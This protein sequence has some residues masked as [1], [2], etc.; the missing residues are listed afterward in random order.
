METKIT[1]AALS[2]RQVFERIKEHITTK[3]YSPEFQEVFGSIDA[4]Y[5]RDG[6]AETVDSALLLEGLKLKLQ[7]A[8]AYDRVAKFVEVSENEQVSV[9]NVEQFVI[10]ARRYELEVQLG[11]ALINHSS[12]NVEKM[13]EEYARLR[14]A[15]TLGAEDDDSRVF[16]GMPVEELVERK[17]A[18]ANLIKLAPKS[19]ND[20][21]DGGCNLGHT[22]LIFGPP[23]IGKS[24]A[25]ITITDGLLRQGLKGIWLENEEP[26]TDTA[27]RLVCAS[28]G[29]DKWQVRGD[30]RGTNK[31]A[32]ENGYE[33]LT[34]AELPGGTLGQIEALIKEHQPK[35][36]VINQLLNLDI[37]AD[38]EPLRLQRAAQMLRY[39][40]K[41][42]Q[43]LVIAVTQGAESSIGKAVLGRAD[44]YFSKIGVPGA[45]DLMIGVGAT[46]E[47]EENGDRMYSLVKNKIGG[48]RGHFPVRLLGPL[49]RVV[50]VGT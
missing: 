15:E 19:L 32:Q 13:L 27:L 1:R 39:L 38:G 36:I 29:R 7:S 44:V 8:K 35:F 47:M 22:V 6:A 16:S 3:V 28:T 17:M 11:Q 46:E 50:S 12:K 40:A 25:A 48:V 4:Y 49:S 23:E 10:S 37:K 5:S 34:F 20:R 43:I 2:S 42:Y 33:L 21:L 41:K 26:V 14:D 24:A 31:I 30:P 45:V 9:P 18:E